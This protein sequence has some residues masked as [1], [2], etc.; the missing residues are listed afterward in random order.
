MSEY[1][2]Q[3]SEGSQKGK[4]LLDL[5]NLLGVSYK[6]YEPA[7]HELPKGKKITRELTAEEEKEAFIYTSKIYAS[8]AFAGKI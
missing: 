3:I 1:V 7:E 2:I 8:R 6:R 4:I 5:L